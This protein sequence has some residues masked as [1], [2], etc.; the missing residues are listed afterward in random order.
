MSKKSWRNCKG[1]KFTILILIMGVWE[2]FIE[3]LGNIGFFNFL[4]GVL[5]FTLVYYTLLIG[6]EKSRNREAKKYEKLAFFIIAIFCASLIFI[7]S[8]SQPASVIFTYV[9]LI[10]FLIVLFL[11]F[12]ILFVSFFGKPNWKFWEFKGRGE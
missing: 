4:L 10:F 3:T 9:S 11:F 1:L 5:I 8:I 12:M 2:S 7:F 6:L